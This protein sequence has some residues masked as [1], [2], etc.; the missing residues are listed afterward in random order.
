MNKKQIVFAMGI[1]IVGFVVSTLFLA[2]DILSIDRTFGSKETLWQV[3]ISGL[4][5]FGYY[6]GILGLIVVVIGLC[7]WIY[8]RLGEETL[9]NALC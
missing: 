7:F 9:K 4:I 2:Y 8:D 1:A 3:W 6:A 5:Q